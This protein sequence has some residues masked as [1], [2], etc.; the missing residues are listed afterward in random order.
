MVRKGMKRI[1]VTLN[2]TMYNQLCELHKKTRVTKSMI[3]FALLMQ[4]LQEN[5]DKYI[6]GVK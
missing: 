4:P 5:Y 1:T 3:V 6:K 2:D